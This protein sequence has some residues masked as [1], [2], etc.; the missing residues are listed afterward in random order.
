MGSN[1]CC[2]SCSRCRSVVLRLHESFV[3]RFKLDRILTAGQARTLVI[4]YILKGDVAEIYEVDDA[5]LSIV[6]YRGD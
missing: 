5:R 1:P 3:N 4:E 2:K 6:Q